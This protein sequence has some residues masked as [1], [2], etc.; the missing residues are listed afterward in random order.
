MLPGAL[1]IESARILLKR[2]LPRYRHGEDERIKTRV[3]ERLLGL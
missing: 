2:T 1:P 3:I